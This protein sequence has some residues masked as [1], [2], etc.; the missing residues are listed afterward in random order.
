MCVFKSLQLLTGPSFLRVC[1]F[2]L[3]DQ[4]HTPVCETTVALVVRK[5]NPKN[6]RTWQ[7]LL[8][9]GLQVC[10]VPRRRQTQ[11][12]RQGSVGAAAA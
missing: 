10:A 12:D 5:G 7:D 1:A 3:L 8:Q 11:A 4:Q 6:V 2:F 9:P